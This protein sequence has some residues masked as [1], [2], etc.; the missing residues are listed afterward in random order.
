M[1]WEQLQSIIKQNKTIHT[2]DMNTPPSAC[3]IDGA[4]LD[5]HPNGV[6]NCPLG[7]YRFG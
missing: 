1:S 7:N 2:R 5:V 3:P 6:R 4:V